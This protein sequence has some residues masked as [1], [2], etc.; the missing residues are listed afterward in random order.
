MAAQSPVDVAQL[1]VADPGQHP[2]FDGTVFTVDTRPFWRDS[3]VSP[4]DFGYHWNHNGE[5]HFLIGKGMGDGMV[6]LL[7]P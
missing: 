7:T 5:A 3:S 4:S 1:A 6:D 2:E